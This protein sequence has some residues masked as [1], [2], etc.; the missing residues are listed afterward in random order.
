MSACQVTEVDYENYWKQI[1]LDRSEA[2]FALM[3]QDSS[4]RY[5]VIHHSEFNSLKNIVIYKN[6]VTEEKQIENFVD[7]T[8]GQSHQA[9]DKIYSYYMLI[10][11]NARASNDLDPLADSVFESF[12]LGNWPEINLRISYSDR[13]DSVYVHSRDDSTNWVFPLKD[14]EYINRISPECSENAETSKIVWSTAT[15]A[16]KTRIEDVH[17]HPEHA[18]VEHIFYSYFGANN[19]KESYEMY[20]E[21]R[22]LKMMSIFNWVIDEGFVDKSVQVEW[23]NPGR[24][25][26]RLQEIDL[27]SNFLIVDEVTSFITQH[28]SGHRTPMVVTT[29]GYPNPTVDLLGRITSPLSDREEVE[30][31]SIFHRAKS[32]DDSTVTYLSSWGEKSEDI[33]TFENFD[34]VNM[35]ERGPLVKHWNNLIGERDYFNDYGI[36][37]RDLQPVEN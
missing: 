20:L 24:A 11:K 29:K 5:E 35:A 18:G 13:A 21:K 6:E 23:P 1:D 19:P 33:D 10:G 7:R 17:T 4:V 22:N 34:F 8:V 14:E 36:Y 27:G 25:P 26:M 15:T 2:I 12:C 16:P 28:K 37:Y 32:R 3:R 30:Y 9:G 31:L